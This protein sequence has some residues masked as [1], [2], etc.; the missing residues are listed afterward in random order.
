M[1]KH[2]TLLICSGFRE[3]RQ[4][5][6]HAFSDT[7]NLLEAG[8][9]RQLALLLHQNLSCI[10]AV[11]LDISTW[12]KP[13]VQRLEEEKKSIFLG[14][15]P[16]IFLVRED[17]SA[18]LDQAFDMGAAD[19]IPIGY[20]P[21][22]ML[23]RVENIVDLHLH[24]QHLET[25][26]E[27]QKQI[28]RHTSDTMVD[29]LSSI[30]EYRSVE[31]GQ[32]VLRIRYFT[33]LLLEE[34]AKCCPEYG[35]TRQTIDIICSAS[36]L[37]D[38]G[39]IAIPDSILMKPGALTEE[40]RKTMQ[41]HTLTG[42]R[43]IETLEHMADKEYLR[44]AHN[45]CHYHHERWDGGGYP[46]GIRE[47]AIPI[48]AQV[49]GLA[50]VYDALTSKR[51]YKDAFS[52]ARAV[53]M[54]FRGECGVFSPKLLDCFKHVAH[55]FEELA[56]EYA[57]G[58]AAPK[59]SLK[60]ELPMPES[61]GFND[62]M[63]RIRGNYFALVHY[64]NG[65]LIELDMDRQLFHL[66]YNPYP[67]LAFF[68]E[69]D[70][71][72]QIGEMLRS[73]FV[74]P[75]DRKAMEQFLSEEIGSF[76]D[77]GQRRAS[78]QIRARGISAEGDLFELTLMRIN[79]LDNSHRTLAVLARKISSGETG[80]REGASVPME[81][82]YLCRND[83]NFTLLQAGRFQ[84]K[85]AGYSIREVR[86]IFGGRLLELA[87]PEDRDMIRREFTRQ[88]RTGTEVR[89]EYR[90][91]QKDGSVRWVYNQSRLVTDPQ[92]QEAISSFLVDIHNLHR[93]DN[94]LQEKLQRYEMI[95]A[96]TEN[97]LFEW[98]ISTDT[99]TFSDTWEKIFGYQPP[100]K[101]CRWSQQWMDSLYPDDV[102]L[103]AD[104]FGR[105][106]NGSHY[107]MIELRV[108]TAQGRYL[109]CRFRATA[110]RD[111]RGDLQKI[112]GIII[113]IDAEKQAE[114]ALQSRAEQDSLT[115]LLNKDAARKQAEEYFSRVSGNV[116]GAL[117]ILDLDD[118]KQV[119]D[120]KGHLF[121]DAVL[122]KIAQE[123]R[124]LFR[125]QDIVA[126]IGGDE[127][128]VVMRGVTDRNLLEQ[129]CLQLLRN[130]RDSFRD[131]KL[132]LSC[133]V[134]IALA[135]QH[136]RSYY[137]LFQHADQALYRTKASG[138][139]G[140][141]IYTPADDDYL[142]QP[143]RTAVVSNPIDS[144]REPGMA[145]DN[146]VRYAFRKLYSSQNVESSI[147]ELLEFIGKKTNVSRVYVFENSDDNRFCSNTFEWCNQGIPSEIDFLQN[148]SYETDI[149]RYVDNFDEQGIF[150][151]PDVELLPRNVYDI[152]A[153]QGIKAMLHCAIR[154]NGVFRGYI[155]FD[156]CEQT[157]MWTREQIDILTFF[158]EAL[159]MFLLRQRR[160][161]KV[162]RQAEDLRSILDS[163]NAWIYVVD[164][165]THALIY[166][167]SRLREKFPMLDAGISCHQLLENRENPC[168]LCPVELLQKKENH[169]CL[170]RGRE[171]HPDV[172][173][174]ATKIRWNDTQ[175]VLVSGREI[176][177]VSEKTL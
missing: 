20:D 12:E 115:K 24:K 76:L 93:E 47:E 43:I 67:E 66:I 146:I 148:I 126:R 127:F 132:R 41:S 136:G 105:L 57:D 117:L 170:L 29:A 3:N 62:A 60:T 156:D 176:P 14:S 25:L 119:N 77:K 7:F 78:F 145:N 133:S 19:V 55:Q 125:G 95:L 154:E 69:A 48:C 144:D 10:A 163:Q 96:Q 172:L 162:Q 106:K 36:A 114:Q 23:R 54:I 111:N 128:L 129:R 59:E 51:V 134:G 9:V 161:E 82:T 8:D 13:E 64:I 32:H 90:I 107:E 74:H 68:Q 79:P 42:C 92:G 45:I 49:V 151:C 2:D 63:E 113:N 120:Q 50:D 83:Q 108:A 166:I 110:V 152:V 102:P 158:S 37:H 122:V 112:N 94:L 27:E 141:A 169:S 46:E 52:F 81:A 73:R 157:R 38:I 123:I 70:S 171:G 147:N 116:N 99:I 124:K 149:P 173:L 155:G 138:K 11:V 28:L 97:V 15:I 44:Y 150:Y 91:I 140:Y 139:N 17:T 58:K 33:Q 118:F 85:L 135:P 65:L 98:D 5:L 56:A 1:V 175:A 4:T 34:V 16:V 53:N 39:K 101:N 84:E 142:N 80:I 86:E 71:L 22:A 35:L 153:P 89:L 6:R 26:V 109:W 159:S 75:E 30:I 18:I 72:D 103:L 40:E 131:Y 165:Q 31:T 167:N 168:G 121:G 174:E 21:Y 100:D 160:Q 177:A 137:E 61:Q 143:G 87:H 88:L 104:I 164:P 130:L